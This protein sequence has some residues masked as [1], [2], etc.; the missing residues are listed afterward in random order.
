MFLT[1]AMKYCYAEEGVSANACVLGR[2]YLIYE[3]SH[4]HWA[5]W[6][7]S[8]QTL[9]VALAPQPWYYG[10][11]VGKKCNPELRG[12]SDSEKWTL[13]GSYSHFCVKTCSWAELKLPA[14]LSDAKRRCCWEFL[15]R[16]C[17]WESIWHQCNYLYTQL[18]LMMIKAPHTHTHSQIHTPAQT[19][20]VAS[21]SRYGDIKGDDY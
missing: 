9:Q 8:D 6:V 16:A 15:T 4:D 3:S 11:F 18:Y 20:P 13:R 14:A 12:I 21:H 10:Q 17:E 1:V 19:L 7:V 5:C 2:Q